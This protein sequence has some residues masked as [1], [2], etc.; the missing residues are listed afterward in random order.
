MTCAAKLL[1][2]RERSALHGAMQNPFTRTLAMWTQRLAPTGTNS[3]V[4]GPRYLNHP[5]PDPVDEGDHG[6]VGRR[7]TPRWN[8]C[9]KGMAATR[10]SAHARCATRCAGRRREAVPTGDRKS[11][12]LNSSHT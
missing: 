3:L 2:S 4:I 8:V 6:L 12:R 1:S 11:T 10:Q 7:C 5:E 9:K